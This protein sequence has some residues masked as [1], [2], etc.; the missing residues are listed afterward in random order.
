V[1]GA[2]TTGVVEAEIARLN[3][4]LP[5][6]RQIHAF[7]IETQPLTFESGLLTANGKLRR[8]AIAE[9]F[10]DAIDAMYRRDVA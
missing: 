5:H 8:A 3:A 7:H 4:L 10:R 1:T 9:R 2:V 6:Y